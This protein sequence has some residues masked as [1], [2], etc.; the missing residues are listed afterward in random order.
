M[1]DSTEGKPKKDHGNIVSIHG[2]SV[3]ISELQ[4]TGSHHKLTPEQ[5]RIV[6]SDTFYVPVTQWDYYRELLLEY[7]KQEGISHTKLRDRIMEPEDK[8][9]TEQ[10]LLTGKISQDEFRRGKKVRANDKLS[11][12][13]LKSWLE[14]NSSKR[15]EKQFK[16]IDRFIV[17]EIPDGL[18]SLIKKNVALARRKYHVGALADMFGHRHIISPRDLP[19]SVLNETVFFGHFSAGNRK[20]PYSCLLRIESE[21]DIAAHCTLIVFW[22]GAD[23]S[24]ELRHPID[25][26]QEDHIVEV[27][28]GSLV[29]LDSELRPELYDCPD[30]GSNE[31]NSGLY[32]PWLHADFFFSSSEASDP[33]SPVRSFFEHQNTI[34]MNFSGEPMEVQSTNYYERVSNTISRC[35]FTSDGYRKANLSTAYQTP[36]IIRILNKYCVEW[37]NGA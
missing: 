33:S 22:D 36:E 28:H 1:C 26:V 15:T 8:I 19:L 9:E 17:T 5:L 34:S 10:A 7:Q 32:E 14:G 21:G 18:Y 25:I 12:T 4:P 11:M 3:S 29:Y 2:N 37:T 27:A 20:T 35:S 24:H 23:L 13:D 31:T 30:G 6:R 16:Y